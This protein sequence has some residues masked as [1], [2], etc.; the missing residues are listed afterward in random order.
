MLLEL[1]NFANIKSKKLEIDDVGI[2]LINGDSGVGK[3]TIFNA[4]TFVF[5]DHLGLSFYPRGSEPNQ[6]IYVKLTYSNGNVFYRQKRK[7]LFMITYEGVT[8]KNDQAEELVN[9][10]FGSMNLFLSSTYLAQDDKWFF[11]NL[12]NSEKLTVLQEIADCN[13]LYYEE[14]QRKCNNKLIQTSNKISE[15]NVKHEVQVGIYNNTLSQLQ[16]KVDIVKWDENTI[17]TYKNY[18]KI[19]DNVNFDDYG[20]FILNEWRPLKM[21]EY[22]SKLSELQLIRDKNLRD[23][24]KQEQILLNLANLRNKLSGI[25]VNSFDEIP[26]MD[27]KIREYNE[28][29]LFLKLNNKR[30]ILISTIQT[31]E[32]KLNENGVISQPK[33]SI[34][35]LNGMLKI[36]SYPIDKIRQKLKLLDDMNKYYSDKKTYDLEFKKYKDEINE[37][38]KE[39]NEN[40]LIKR[41]ITDKYNG[42]RREIDE[43][44]KI[45]LHQNDRKYLII[46]SSIKS[47]DDNNRELVSKNN[48]ILNLEQQLNK[49]IGE[50]MNRIKICEDQHKD[51]DRKFNINSIELANLKKELETYSDY[52]FSVENEIREFYKEKSLWEIAKN[53]HECPNCKSFLYFSAN[54]LVLVPSDLLSEDEMKRKFSGLVEHEEKYK[55]RLNILNNINMLNVTIENQSNQKIKLNN[56]L[57]TL[58][59]KDF[60]SEAN[61][62][63]K[64]KKSYS[65]RKQEINSTLAGYN[66]ELAKLN[67]D[68]NVLKQKYQNDVNEMNKLEQNEI[69]EFTSSHQ[70]LIDKINTTKKQKIAPTNPILPK[71]CLPFESIS[72]EREKYAS[73]SSEY[74]S[75]PLTIEEITIHQDDIK[76]Y[77]EHKYLSNQIFDYKQKLNELNIKNINI[78]GEDDSITSIE[79]LEDK[80][81][82]QINELNKVKNNKMSLELI[83]NEISKLEKLII[84]IEPFDDDL[85][86]E[87]KKDI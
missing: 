27:D 23:K 81:S 43:K 32:N 34:D 62:I 18:F 41:N 49:N 73:L 10:M 39:I 56:E 82:K 37:L 42:K 75:C 16:D 11:L 29:I 66:D 7:D 22:E 71:G 46:N 72:G 36:L 54:K 19:S 15:L 6:T 65:E 12:K 38:D 21:S 60:S 26:L 48:L 50:N 84:H 44:Y 13:P 68:N 55:K 69:L 30:Q 59:N 76:K 78:S 77:D 28:K 70:I 2:I 8:Y 17:Q 87:C 74:E 57:T 51:L 85:I 45:D 24:T 3:S 31:L 63:E 67:Q 61:A 80:L 79:E 1:S 86:L 4:L 53:K 58:K 47:N 83:N 64:E 14:Y 40:F 52:T 20:S 35:E 25:N 5:Y 9:K 33:H